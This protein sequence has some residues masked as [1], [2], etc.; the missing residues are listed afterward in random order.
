LAY[1][2]NASREN[3][4]RLRDH[5]VW[6]V[7]VDGQH[8]RLV[9]RN[10]ADPAWSPDG[11]TI[12]YRTSC[13]I[14]LVTQAGKDVTPRSARLCHAI[15]VAGQPVW[16]PDGRKIAIGNRRGVYVMNRDGSQLS[17]LTSVNPTG[18]FGFSR[19]TWQPL[20]R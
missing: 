15:G 4:V 3:S 7:D 20:P 17:R 10:A 11:R 19:P 12:A 18:V 8:R 2:T 6:V 1:E 13:G 16:S 9:A 5:F 14:K